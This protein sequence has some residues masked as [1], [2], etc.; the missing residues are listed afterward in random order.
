[1]RNV[2]NLL[3]KR[4]EIYGQLL[5]SFLIM[6]GM[7]LLIS[8]CL[9]SFTMNTVRKQSDQIGQNI[10]EMTK[11][12]IDGQLEGIKEFESRWYIDEGISKIADIE[13][14]IGREYSQ[15]LLQLY[16][17][18]VKQKATDDFLKRAF[19]YFSGSDKIV[20][21]DGNMDFELYYHLYLQ[22]DQLDQEAFRAMLQEHHRY[23]T[24][25]LTRGTAVLDPMMFLSLKSGSGEENSATIGFMMDSRELRKRLPSADTG[26]SGVEVVILPEDGVVLS[27]ERSVFYL[28]TLDYEEIREKE[29]YKSTDGQENFWVTVSESEQTN[30]VYL[31]LTASGAYAE[32]IKRVQL[33]SILGLLLSIF[34]GFGLAWY[35]AKKNYNPFR[36]ITDMV[37]TQMQ[38]VP[39]FDEGMDEF[40]W[41]S[42]QVEFIL[43]KNVNFQKM[44]DKNQKHMREFCR[45]QLLT[46]DCDEEQIKRCGIQFPHEYY[47]TAVIQAVPIQAGDQTDDQTAGLRRFIVWNIFSELAGDRYP[48]EIFEMGN[49]VIAIFNVPQM[50]ESI[51]EAIREM[52]EKLHEMVYSPFHFDI[53]GLI[54]SVHVGT[55]GIKTSYLEALELEEYLAPLDERIISREDICGIEPEYEY[56]DGIDEKLVLAVQAGDGKLAEQYI[57]ETFEQRFSGKISP[58]VYRGLIYEMIG[59]LLKGAKAGGYMAVASEVPFPDESM[60][61]RSQKET[62]EQLILAAGEIC[63]QIAGIRQ[64]TAENYNLSREVEAYID[65]HYTDPDLNISIA[66]QQFDRTP[67]YLSSIYKKQTGRSLLEYINVKRI[68][69]AEELLKA[70]ASVVEAASQSGFRD[71]GGFIRIFK[72]YRGITP[73]Q[74]KGVKK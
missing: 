53:C 56:L 45:W 67:A 10:L 59:S 7:P 12:D 20:S 23:D 41:L 31:M 33:F 15:L 21:T 4:F 22:N 3:E 40:S 36:Q 30:W 17:E 73:G 48:A 42:H 57:R 61:R 16:Q 13:G 38:T 70:G 18:L 68:D 50:E 55:K 5:L 1:M 66:S 52:L 44:L 71:S 9:Y 26:K 65:E 32:E 62:G 46:A 43:Q 28:D 24:K 39:R 14:K 60:I 11:Q 29:H 6:L 37:R 34:A 58:G 35:L 49:R 72:R 47:L 2:R 69:H 54:G 25:V 51:S 27:P 64:S 74:M 19:I 8:F 63:S